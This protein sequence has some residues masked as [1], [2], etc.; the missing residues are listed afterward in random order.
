MVLEIIGGL[1]LFAL[2]SIAIAEWFALQ[3][4]SQY[5]DRLEE[6]LSELE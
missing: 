1:L 2:G 3:K 4:L 6:M 5:C